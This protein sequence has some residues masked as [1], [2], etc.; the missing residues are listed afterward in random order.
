MK[1][2]LLLLSFLPF[3][4]C[5]N[6][7]SETIDGKGQ[8]TS[9]QVDG[10]LIADGN[11]AKTYEL[12][13]RSGYNHET[14][15]SSREHKTEHFQHIQQVYDTQLDKYVFAFFIHAA[16][17]DDRGLTDVTD[18]QRNEIKTDNK[19]PESLV[20]QE[21][22]TMVF[23]W[24]FCL[25]TG[26]QTTTKFSH[27]HQLKGIDNATNTADVGL[28]LITLTAYSTS[29]GGQQLKLRYNNRYEGTTTLA[30]ANLAD[31]LGN[32]VEVEEKARFGANGSYEIVITRLKDE[33]VLLKLAPTEMDMWR[34]NCTGLRPKWGI[35]R[36]LGE[37]R[38]WQDQLRD[39][40]LRFADFS[41]KK[42]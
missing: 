27:L 18:R 20:G 35:Y 21:G 8:Q 5:S 14:P 24:K 36:Y 7:L 22:E 39:E 29:N 6:S 19:S 25:P 38:S 13:E 41:I 30:S 34:T 16:I 11:S 37:D 4:A 23:R 12:I 3:V 33:K 17:D 1:A 15:D 10:T 9:E 32:W 42:L 2:G 28:P 31:F 26:F 40:E